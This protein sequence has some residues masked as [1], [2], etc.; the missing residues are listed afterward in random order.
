MNSYERIYNLLVETERSKEEI[1][2][3]VIAQ[4]DIANV[5]HAQEGEDRRIAIRAAADLR[6]S[7]LPKDHPRYRPLPKSTPKKL[8]P[9]TRPYA[10]RRRHG[11]GKGPKTG[12]SQ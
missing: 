4:S 7:Q 1:H 6:A 11:R 10:V 9:S 5:R 12:L 8:V 3:E 2:A